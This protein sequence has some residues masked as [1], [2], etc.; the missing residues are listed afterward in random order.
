MNKLPIKW[1][2]AAGLVDYPTYYN[3]YCEIVKP[4]INELYYLLVIRLI[5]PNGIKKKNTIK[6]SRV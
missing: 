3:I 2:R 4:V 1:G 5:E 6:P